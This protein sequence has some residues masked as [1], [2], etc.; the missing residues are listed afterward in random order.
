MFLCIQS[1]SPDSWITFSKYY[2]QEH[3][4]VNPPLYECSKNVSLF[5]LLTLRRAETLNSMAIVTKKDIVSLQCMEMNISSNTAFRCWLNRNVEI[6]HNNV[7]ISSSCHCSVKQGWLSVVTC[8]KA[9]FKRRE[10]MVTIIISLSGT[11]IQHCQEWRKNI[12]YS[13]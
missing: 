10:P 2:E 1:N 11:E 3:I 13:L 5:F 9:N 12:H 4:K 6:R 7:W 8:F